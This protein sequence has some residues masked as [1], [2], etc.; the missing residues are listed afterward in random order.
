[1]PRLDWR[2][3]LALSSVPSFVVL[4]LHRSAPESPRY[5]FM[6][7]KVAD[8][9]HV[10]E[11]IARWNKT[12]LPS[13]M[14]VSDKTS[15]LDNESLNPERVPLIS[16]TIVTKSSNLSV[17][18]LLSSE[19]ITTTL[20]LWVLF[21]GMSF[22]YYGIILL[23]AEL[24]SG[25]AECGLGLLLPDSG[26]DSSLYTDVFITSL[27]GNSSPVSVFFVSKLSVQ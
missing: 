17:L 5:L 6:E 15:R 21:F 24:S 25:Q 27:A 18:T 13:G 8:A 12:T 20:L 16:S 9:H 10:L 3:L 2:W 1:M 22:L 19:L 23:T 11:T 7:G 14:I 4:L 26:Q